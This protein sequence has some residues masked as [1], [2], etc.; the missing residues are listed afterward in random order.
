[1]KNGLIRF[2]FFL[3]QLQVLLTRASK[4]KNPA[5]WLYQ[6]NARTPLF[7]L[8]GLAK[9]YAGIHDK[10]KFAKIKEHFKLLEDVLGAIDY[11]DAFAKEFTKNKHIPGTVT[12]YLQAQ[13]REKIQSLNEM[14]KENGW[15]GDDNK[16]MSKIRKKLDKA[17][18][19][20]EKD[21]MEKIAAFY[22]SSIATITAFAGKSNFHFKNVEA[23]VHELRRKLRWLSI[24]PQALRGCIQLSKGK[25]QPK[26]LAKYLTKEIITSPFNIIPDAGDDQYIL[27]LEKNYFYALSWMIA[28]LGKL[29]DNGL[30]VIVIK[31]ALQQTAVIS[32]GAAFKK[33]YAFTGTGQPHIR[34]LLDDADAL[35]KTYFKEN[36]L[37]KLLL[38]ITSVKP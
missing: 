33:A 13:T 15:L 18:W 12:G 9:L 31:E 26:Y 27:L 30:R 14:L 25:A 5:L 7:M 16:R 11:Y 10:K 36:N 34:Q 35:C 17:D 22:G 8:E 2:N 38:G 3:D 19:L 23:D 1:M 4:Q 6:N 28:A 24:Y 32:D 21:E 29:K 20:K 37:Q